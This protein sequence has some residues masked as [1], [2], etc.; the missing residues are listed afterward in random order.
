MEKHSFYDL[1]ASEEIDNLS[2]NELQ[3]KNPRFFYSSSIEDFLSHDIHSILGS[4]QHNNFASETLIQQSNTW[5]IEIAILKNQLKDIEEG[6]IIFEYTIPRMGKRVDVILLHQNIVFLLE[7]KCGDKEYRSS[8]DDQVYDYALDL[9]NFQKESH[10]KLLAA[11]TVSTEAS[12]EPIKIKEKI[13]SL[14]QSGV[15]NQIS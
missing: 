15:I 11:I 2:I 7:F 13:V 3:K 5:E 14:N 4:I 9:R 8:A 10:D 6:R 1:S 12:G